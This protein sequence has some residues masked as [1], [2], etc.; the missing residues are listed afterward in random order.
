MKQFFL[1]PSSLYVLFSFFCLV[2]I[3]IFYDGYRGV[4]AEANFLE[5]RDRQEIPFTT[6]V[7]QARQSQYDRIINYVEFINDHDSM[8]AGDEPL[9]KRHKLRWLYKSVEVE[10]Y[11]SLAGISLRL[12]IYANYLHF[13][14]WAS[15]SLIFMTLSV[16]RI[17][18]A[19]SFENFAV[20]A[21]ALYA[22]ISLTS[23][24][25]RIIE[26][27]TII[28]MG[29]I[30]AAIYFSLRGKLLFFLVVLFIGV[31]N[32]ETGAAMGIIYAL[33][34]WRQTWFWLPVI[35]GPVFLAIIN[36]KL[37]MLPEFLDVNKFVV[38]NKTVFLTIFNIVNAPLSLIV[39]TA[40]K[41]FAVL[42]PAF[43]FVPRAWNSEIGKKLLLIGAFYL[44]ILLFGTALGN[45]LPYGLLAP[46]LISL[47]AVAYSEP[48]KTI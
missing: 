7:E 22:Y 34:N 23:S 8:G 21:T 35:G 28:E 36:L 39:F 43:V 38:S 19:I 31:S 27:H 26:Q 10:V 33:I 42:I 48:V 9:N 4:Y 12:A 11:K 25:P 20:I 3:L 45:M 32:R 18:G 46:I 47:G 14:L 5:G 30:S 2:F 16:N 37:L 40:L 15:I 17:R 6:H 1:K 29:V 44:F 24:I 13:S 41:T